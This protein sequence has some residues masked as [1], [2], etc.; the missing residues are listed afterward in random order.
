ML[1]ELLVAI[2]SFLCGDMVLLAQTGD[3]ADLAQLLASKAG[4]QRAIS[5]VAASRA[6][7]VPLLL[8]LAKTSPPDVDEHDLYVGLAYAFGALKVTEAI[9]FLLRRISIRTDELIDLR[10]WLKTPDVIQSSFPAVAALISIGPE[11]SR[12][13]MLAYAQP[14]TPEERLATV[15]VVSQIPGVPEARSFLARVVGQAN[16]ERYFAQEGRKQ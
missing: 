15:F 2:L 6:E 3:P 5:F 11:A 12:A 7:R 4:T 14:M 16:I 1:K 13:A 8:S 10:P 9:P